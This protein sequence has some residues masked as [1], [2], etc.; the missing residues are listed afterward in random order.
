MSSDQTFSTTCATIPLDRARGAFLGL[1]LGDA[2]G[3]PLEFLQGPR[4]R[5]KPVAVTAEEFRWTDDTHMALYLAEAVLACGAGALNANHFGTAVGV[6]FY[7]WL[8]DPLTPT[9]APGRTCL[10]GA[11]R[12]QHTRDWRSSGDRDSD[13]C[14]AVMRI[15]PLAL[16]LEAD[17]LTTAARVSAAITHAHPNA[18]EAA[19]A[20]SHL[21]RWTLEEGRF[22]ADL[23]ERTIDGLRGP[24][25]FGGGTVRGALEAAI[26]QSRRHTRWLDEIAIPAGDGGW[27]APSALGLAVNAALRWG[28]DFETAIDKAAR[29]DGDS[30][31]VAC[32]AG[33]FLGAAGGCTALPGVWLEVLPERE[34]IESLAERLWKQ[35]GARG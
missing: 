17:D 30:D 19:V 20:G 35:A 6:Q 27:R 28:E 7:R 12:W 1:A 29:I 2:Y 32:L 21:L 5:T 22:G 33:M 26:E 31:S 9:T 8:Q 23:V 11:V 18:I 13:G 34:H 24:W 25:R 16:A 4:V 15:C 14:G 3:R 10:K